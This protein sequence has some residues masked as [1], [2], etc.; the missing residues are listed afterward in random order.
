VRRR[1]TRK[2]MNCSFSL[3][4]THLFIQALI[5]KETAKIYLDTPTKISPR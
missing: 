2:E 5:K 3:H 4:F 1:P